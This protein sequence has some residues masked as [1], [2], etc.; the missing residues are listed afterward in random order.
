MFPPDWKDPILGTETGPRVMMATCSWHTGDPAWY[1][2]K[3]KYYNKPIL[4]EGTLICTVA[5]LDGI[6]DG[7]C[8]VSKPRVWK[9]EGKRDSERKTHVYS[10]GQGWAGRSWS[11]W[12][13]P[14]KDMAT[15]IHSVEDHTQTR[16]WALAHHCRPLSPV[17]G[18]CAV[19]GGSDYPSGFTASVLNLTSMSQ[20]SCL[21]GTSHQDS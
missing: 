12:N 18:L 21:W 20:L 11:S 4:L 19:S 5:F 7:G 6:V 2:E 1:V 13:R 8:P 9:M 3:G 10:L 16:Q 15:M 14:V 17:S